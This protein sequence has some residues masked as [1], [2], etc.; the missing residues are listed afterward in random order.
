MVKAFGEMRVMK[1]KFHI[2]MGVKISAVVIAFVCLIV[3]GKG[4]IAA[5]YRQS[6]SDMMHSEEAL[7]AVPTAAAAQ[8][9]IAET[10]ENAAADALYKPGTITVAPKSMPDHITFSAVGDN[11][12]H[13][14][15]INQAY[16]NADYEGYDF[17]YCYADVAPFFQSRDLSWINVETII[18]NAIEP[19]GYPNFSTPASSGN[20]LYN[21]GFDI[22]SLAS[23]HTYDYGDYGVLATR[24]YWENDAPKNILTTGIWTDDAY[25]PVYAVNGHSIAFL[26]YS[27]GSNGFSDGESGHIITL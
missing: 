26:T 11:L 4:R 5:E 27:Y 1:G 15:L 19:S 13:E 20:A 16:A 3:V 7:L 18:N 17:S 6:L 22:Y 21:A 10:V 2:S 8:A 12:I 23:N 25:I 9:K 14:T 24:T